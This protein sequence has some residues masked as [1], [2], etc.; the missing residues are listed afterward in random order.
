MAVPKRKTS[1]S[2][3]GM[4]RSADAL[5]RPSYVED[6]DSGELR[7]PAPRRSQD[8]YVQGPA[9]AQAQNRSLTETC[10]GIGATHGTANGAPHAGRRSGNRR[11]ARAC[12]VRLGAP[13]PPRLRRLLGSGD[14][15][16]QKHCGRPDPT[17]PTSVPGQDPTRTRARP[18]CCGSAAVSTRRAGAP[19]SDC[20]KP[21]RVARAASGGVMLATARILTASLIRFVSIR[22][23]QV[24]PM[25]ISAR[26]MPKLVGP[27]GSVSRGRGGFDDF[28]MV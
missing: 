9:G 10:D 19:P 1:P 17:G 28:R 7:R 6:K 20:A 15:L 16:S 27:A 14:E 8:R 22:D 18:L 26:R 11:V 12:L 25:N 24:R 3:R 23:R 13:A 4:R 2:R 5:K 21:G